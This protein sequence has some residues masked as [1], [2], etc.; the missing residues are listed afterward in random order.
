MTAAPRRRALSS[1]PVTTSTTINSGDDEHCHHLRRKHKALIIF[2][3]ISLSRRR[4]QGDEIPINSG[5]DKHYHQLRRNHEALI[6][7]RHLGL[8]IIARPLAIIAATL[9]VL[10]LAFLRNVAYDIVSLLL[11][12]LVKL[13][14]V[15]KNF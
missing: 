1:T 9:T 7:Q 5:N 12:V 3:P 13:S 10:S 6:L 11:L 15:Q 4:H 8:A 2:S 14:S